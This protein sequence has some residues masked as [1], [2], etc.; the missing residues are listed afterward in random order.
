MQ[1][2]M[3]RRIRE[4]QY[5][6]LYPRYGKADVEQWDVTLLATLI[7]ELFPTSL[8]P[9]DI[10]LIKTEIRGTRNEL[11]HLS[12]TS[13]M[14]DADFDKY[15]GRLETAAKT[16]AKQV[17]NAKD[18]AS[19]LKK[20]EF[21]KRNNL[22]NLGDCLRVWFEDNL[23]EVNSN[24]REM[25][26]VFKQVIAEIP[27]TSGDTKKRIKVVDNIFT[28][29]QES[30]ETTIK[31][32]PARSISVKECAD[33]R[34]KLRDK[35]H[36]V[37]TG[38]YNSSYTETAI[39]AVKGMHYDIKRSVEMSISLDWRHIDPENV[40]LVFC[41]NPFGSLSYDESK[42]KGIVDMFNNMIRT[43]KRNRPLD[44]VIVTDF[45]ILKK[46]KEYHDHELLEEVVK[47]FGDTSETQP[48]DLTL[49]CE[50]HKVYST[51]LPAVHNLGVLTSNYLKQHKI[52]SLQVDKDVLKEAK[53]KFKA[54][55]AIVLTGPR[56]CGKTSVAVALASFYKP[57]QCL[58]LTDPYDFKALDF[59]ITCLVIIEDFTGKY[60]YDKKDV[61][62]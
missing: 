56:K 34:T 9:L 39:A 40:D 14:A 7:T 5:D 6:L 11:Q 45:Q 16:L 13:N 4:D 31:E 62:R 27:G 41:R 54:K 48:A 47:V 58:L 22:P 32:V 18:E 2:K 46:L 53:G 24:T 59:Q 17:F 10:F 26:S 15:W 19:F 12:S 21:A 36:V 3:K 42:A 49:G 43:T 57:C 29:L 28:K 38:S 35:H 50:N 30:F 61:C 60:C 8:Q 44:I 51:Y 20:M 33:I 1:L 25:A 55:K 37:V 23:N 52:S